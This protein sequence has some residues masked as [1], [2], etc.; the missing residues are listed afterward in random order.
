MIALFTIAFPLLLALLALGCRRREGWGK[1]LLLLGA[2][3]NLAGTLLALTLLRP[4]SSLTW[5]GTLWLQAG[6]ALDSTFALLTSALF[7]L[8]AVHLQRW[9]PQEVAEHQAHAGGGA[10]LSEGATAACL[11][12][13]LASM[14]T[15]IWAA[16]LGLMW[17]AVEATT[18]ATAPLISFKRTAR[19]LEAMWKYLLICSVGIGLALLGTM[20]LS[21]SAHAACDGLGLAELASAS[22]QFHRGW[23]KVA[24]LLALAGFGTKMGLAPFHTWLPD[25]HSEAP[26]PVSALLSGTLLNGAFLGIVRFVDL[27]PA[28][29]HSFC[30]GPLLGLGLASLVFA[31][32]FIVRQ[33]DC[34]R[35]LAYSSVE[36]MG[37][38]AIML[39]LTLD[40][41][42]FSRD[43]MLLHAVGH[44]LIKVA[45]FLL[46]GNILLGYGTR[47]VERIEGLP[48]AMPRTAAGW[49]AG[50][51]LICGVPPSPLFLTEFLL[52]TSAGVGVA[53]TVMLLLLVIAGGMLYA[54]L[55]M[56][57]G[58]GSGAHLAAGAADRLGGVPHWLLLA[59][60][61]LGLMAVWSM[62][63]GGIL[64]NAWGSWNI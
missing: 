28:D 12:G 27:A 54:G 11:L 49:L 40:G 58:S 39:A 15:V 17:V 43:W 22:P 2:G 38:L 21:V 52:V 45:L 47:Q 51:L 4:A 1:R 62:V 26:A 63:H 41:G 31:A 64:L 59:A 35:M 32:V 5:F 34:K 16:N 48:E 36:H 44:S 33:R 50:L 10:L 53:V 56:C 42:Y 57:L 61:V 24:F 18:L 19:S 25:A 3:G 60:A 37:L 9:W 6:S 29:L 30:Q 14:S 55:K 23:F 7:L 20:L 8:T 13:F 46:A